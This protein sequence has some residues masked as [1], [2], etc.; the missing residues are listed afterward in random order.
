MGVAHAGAEVGDVLVLHPA[1]AEEVLWQIV[2]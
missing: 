1:A 2:F